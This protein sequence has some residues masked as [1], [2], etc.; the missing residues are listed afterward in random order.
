MEIGKSYRLRNM[1]RN[2]EEKF[3][4]VTRHYFG[5]EETNSYLISCCETGWPRDARRYK[6]G[7]IFLCLGLAHVHWDTGEEDNFVSVLTPDGIVT[8]LALNGS[9]TKFKEI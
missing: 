8:T 2:K 3:K 9:K 6:D 5:G 4:A 1:S 7:D